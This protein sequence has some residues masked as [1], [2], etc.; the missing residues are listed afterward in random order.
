MN[1][2]FSVSSTSSSSSSEE[3]LVVEWSLNKLYSTIRNVKN[4]KLNDIVTCVVNDIKD[5]GRVIYIGKI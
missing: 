1:K 3:F 4:V 2:S 5:T